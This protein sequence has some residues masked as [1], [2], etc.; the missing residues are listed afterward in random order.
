MVGADHGTG[1]LSLETACQGFTP[2]GWS[3]RPYRSTNTTLSVQIENHPEAPPRNLGLADSYGRHSICQRH[4]R[5]AAMV[6]TRAWRPT[7]L[8]NG[9]PISRWAVDQPITA[10]GIFI[11]RVT[12]EIVDGDP[13]SAVK[14]YGVVISSEP[15]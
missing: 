8:E 15:R 9:T 13:D 7:T 12:Q 14:A 6:L 1:S 5:R 11:Q 4:H 3:T 10:R 2:P